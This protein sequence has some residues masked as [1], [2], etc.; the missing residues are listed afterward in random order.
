MAHDLL[1]MVKLY[2]FL[3]NKTVL[4]LQ[5]DFAANKIVR[6]SFPQEVIG[7]DDIAKDRI[8]LGNHSK[9]KNWRE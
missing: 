4:Y 1:D 6:V 5:G 7:L 8:F 2:T 9:G 3:D